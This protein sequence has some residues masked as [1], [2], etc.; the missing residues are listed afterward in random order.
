[1]TLDYKLL[2]QRTQQTLVSFLQTQLKFGLTLVQTAHVSADVG[3]MDHYD[4]AKRNATKAAEVARRFVGQVDD[5]GVKANIA[6]QLV[7]LDRLI[8]KL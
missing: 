7:E 5:D 8:S 4:Q 3:H 1:L 2:R 6:I